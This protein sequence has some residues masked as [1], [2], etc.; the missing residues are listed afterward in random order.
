M[1]QVEMGGKMRIL[2]NILLVMLFTA[3]MVF[4]GF[5]FYKISHTIVP[6]HEVD[7][8]PFEWVSRGESMALVRLTTTGECFLYVY[9]VAVAKAA[10]P[11]KGEK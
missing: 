7:N 1:V 9:G 2:V 8:D 5:T 10:C 11:T 4:V 6:T 3:V